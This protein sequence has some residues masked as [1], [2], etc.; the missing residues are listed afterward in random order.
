MKGLFLHCGANIVEDYQQII[1]AVTPQE[2]DTHKPLPHHIFIDMVKNHFGDTMTITEENHS[3]SHEGA[4]YFGLMKVERKGIITP[5]YSCVL[6]LRNSH[7]KKFPAALVAGSSVF[8]CDN[9]SFSGEEKAQRRHTRFMMRD[10][11][12]VISRCFARLNDHWGFQA[13]RFDAYKDFQ[14][15]DKEASHLLLRAFEA[16]AC[17][18]NDIKGIWNQWNTPNHPEFQDRNA[19]SLFNAFTENLKGNLNAL[20]KRTDALHGILDIH[21]E[22]VNECI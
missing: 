20:P 7:D 14:L 13:K 2:T 3:L 11:K 21:C 18:S 4:R 16:G 12:G 1:D 6:G 5:D 15:G 9:L 17:R 8:V 19:W 22:V 10:L